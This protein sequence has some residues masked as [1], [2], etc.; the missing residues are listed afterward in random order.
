MDKDLISIIVPAYNIQP[1]L[2]RCLESLCR[3]THSNLEV[4]VV[5]DGSTDG[6]GRLLDDWASR[7]S[8]II[9]IHQPNGG[10]TRARRS[11]MERA[12]GAYIGFVDGDDVAEPD[13]FEILLSDAKTYHADIAHCGYQM[14]FPDGHIDYYYGSGKV[15][16]QDQQKGIIDLLEGKLVEPG[17]CNKLYHRSLIE[18]LMQDPR[19]DD[20]IRI[21]EDLLMNFLLFSYAHKSIF[22]DE[23]KYH[24]MLRKG[25]AATSKPQ[26]YKLL[27]PQ[28]VAEILCRETAG[29]PQQY[30]AALCRYI[31]VLMGNTMQ[32]EYPE[33]AREAQKIL[34]QQQKAGQFKHLPVKERYMAILSTNA[35]P[36][37]RV[38]RWLYEK[39]TRIDHKYDV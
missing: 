13:M 11:G 26:P 24:Y 10:V 16:E 22:R 29:D 2:S 27:D 1:Y 39:I 5:D 35:K 33:I 32:K 36:I 9:A 17:L 4:I 7:D 14:V 19:M 3:Q 12:S 15:L 38:I 37:Y 21:N 8:R 20:K 31:R 6:T 23:C 34:K 18:R 25:S 28:R 30:S